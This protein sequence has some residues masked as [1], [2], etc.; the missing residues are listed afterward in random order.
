MWTGWPLPRYLDLF[1]GVAF[2]AV[3]IQVTLFHMRS[4]FHQPTQWMPVLAT[5]ALGIT[6]LAL[7]WYDGTLLRAVFSALAIFG[8]AV[9]L[10]GTYLHIAGTGRRVGGYTIHN[11]MVGPPPML[12]LIV[13]A[14]SA[15]SF[16]ALY[17]G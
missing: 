6:A 3:F 17:A 14:L 16:V 7:T 5:P 4:N 12:P 13:V 15:L 11:L 1:L 10:A 9:G 2:L 8:L